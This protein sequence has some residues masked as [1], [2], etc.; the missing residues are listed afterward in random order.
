MI[1]L[2]EYFANTG[3]G[4]YVLAQ[5][6]A[7]STLTQ[8]QLLAQA[9]APAVDGTG[10]VVTQQGNRFDISGGSLSDDGANL[11]HSF[12]RLGLDSE[13][14]VNFISNPQINNILGRVTGGEPSLIN[15]LIQ[16]TGGNS[17]LFLMNPAGIIFGSNVQLNVPASFTATTATGIGLGGNN[18]F[19]AFGENNY[20]TLIG[21]PNIFVFDLSQPGS[22]INA[23]NLAV[24]PGQN[25]ILLGGSVGSTGQLTAPGGTSTVAAV[26]GENLVRISQPGHLLSLE[27]SPQ[28]DNN[29][30]L[31]PIVP[32]SLPS[33]L[34]GTAKDVETG[35]R[36][37]PD[38]T[39]Q[40]TGSD[41]RVENGDVVA[42][43]VTA[44]TATLSAANNLTLVESQ[45][46]TT[47]D[48]TLSAGSTVQIRDS[49]ANPFVAHAGG[50]LYVRGDRG[51]DILALNHPETPFISGGNLTLVSDGNI[52]GD[53]HFASR[54]GFSILNLSAG[55]GNFVSLYDPIIRANG[56]VVFGNY[57]GV[58]LKVE[59]TGSIQGGNITITGPDLSGSIPSFDP[60]FATLTNTNQNGALI[61]RA[62]RDL[63]TPINFPGNAGNTTFQSP[64]TPLLIPSGSIQVGNINTSSL[65][66]GIN[67]GSVILQAT[68]NITTGG[69]NTRWGRDGLAGRG[70]AGNITL[71]SREGAID[72]SN[73]VTS[74]T[75]NNGNGGDISF[76]AQNNI[77]TGTVEASVSQG[78]FQGNLVNGN[79]G[80]ISLSSRAGAI[81]TRNLEAITGNGNGG[82]IT[83][84]AKNDIIIDSVLANQWD[85]VTAKSG[86]IVLTSTEGSITLRGLSRTQDNDFGSAGKITL[87]ANNGS[88][89][90]NR[91]E[92]YSVSGNGAAI[93]INAG[94]DITIDS[95]DTSTDGSGVAG[96]ISLTSKAGA[97]NIKS[98]LSADSADSNG[99]SINL[100]ASGDITTAH[101]NSSGKRNAGNISLTSSGGGIN[102]SAGILNAAGG[103]NGG[104]ITL[105]APKNIATG[106]ITTFL[107]GFSGNSG[108]I[109]ITSSN[110]NIDTSK[111]ALIT[112][113]ALG[114]GGNITLNAADSITAA[115]INAFSFSS[116]GGKIDLTANH[117]ITTSGNIETN[118]N[119]IIFKAPVTLSENISVTSQGTGNIIF[120]NTVNGTQNLILN[121][122]TGIVQF[123]NAVGGSTPLN[124]LLVQGDISTTNPAGVDITTVNNI[125]TGN[126]TS[127]GGITL[128]SNSRN[129]TT[130][131]LDSSSTDN[132]GNVTLNARENVT[133]SQIN[134]QSLG[135]GRGGN[136]DITANRFFR[137]T[138]A[139]PD[140]NG[141]NASISTAGRVD[142]G[143]IIMRHGGGGITPFIAGNAGTNGTQGAITRGNR[144]PA[145]TISPTQTYYPTHK[146]DSDQIQIISVPRV[147]PIPPD[148]NP[149]PNPQL[150]SNSSPDPPQALALLVGD[151]LGADTQINQDPESGDYSFAWRI[152]DGRIL[153][154][155]APAVGLQI[156]QTDDIISSIDKLFE[157]QYEDYYR[158]NITDEVVTVQSLRQTLKTIKSHTG[159]SAVVIYARSFL[160]KLELVLVTPEENSIIK[161]VPEANAA[162]LK[163]QIEGFRNAVNKP[164][165]TFDY[166][167]S[168]KQLYQWLI[169]P[170]ESHLKELNI[171]TLIF[172]MD[173]GMRQIPMAAL[174][175][176]KGKQFLVEKY[177]LGSIPSVSLTNTRYKAWKD[178]DVLAMGASQ[179]KDQ[180]PLYWVPI[181]LDTITPKLL[182]G[183]SFLNEQFT[184]NN[185]KSYSLR[186]DFNIIHLAT[187]A[188]FQ[189][190]HVSNSY[191]QLSDKKLQLDEL[192][193]LGWNKL[194]QVELL[195]LS[196]CRTALGDRDAELGF[197]GLAIYAGVKS[198]L[199]SQ[200]Y[201]DDGGT[202]ALMSGFYYHLS[203]SGVIKAEALQQ[204]QIAM[205]RKKVRLVQG[206]LIGLEGLSSPPKLEGLGNKD[207]TH[208]YYWAGFTLVGSP[209]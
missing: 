14:I 30:N 125:I 95:L 136:V 87:N 197:A 8:Q 114:T 131:I 72:T 209:W 23:G 148:P 177:S 98:D 186:K 166:R 69:I 120:N 93:E 180:K 52:S 190:R 154:L 203:Q 6:P 183:K 145:Q 130:G 43:N 80:N 146:Q 168:S 123:N 110:A 89:T 155:N 39:V 73:G 164:L 92:A 76:V 27:I 9:I 3:F 150:N 162:N 147:P 206:Q 173:A 161:D 90:T 192:R 139:S 169:A 159:K 28:R 94:G 191:I 207:F 108:N 205:L 179:F 75:S 102:T 100:T 42:K 36:V 24:Q 111:G 149:L 104:N 22:I 134:A 174:Y 106:E 16:V 112:A 47:G 142:G 133:V 4:S 152:P 83:I 204:A 97:I 57:T 122:G 53:A 99:T 32:Q 182:R 84:E 151:I 172:C 128:T 109:S 202:Q 50:I 63:V 160:E 2:T 65:A 15:G 96:S 158:E 48:L 196:A 124:N 189:G 11:F 201:V 135:I 74:A 44:Q 13:Q 26:T 141:I 79:S 10:T 61:L 46:R 59:A 40:L 17:N 176:E 200:W 121:P 116:T 144:A 187:H 171:D 21:S 198:A 18:W 12:Q 113:S 188:D 31:L 81:T 156:N 5:L 25:L 105:F 37:N 29:G 54:G 34:T 127:S 107:S 167:K 85:R 194:P 119:D 208:P 45:L 185:L 41:F 140:Q 138:V 20:Q 77:V 62:G 157:Q 64:G 68:G 51:I 181:E 170:F 129:I 35:L 49:V 71:W 126:I 82:S 137:A 60:D 66:D 56:D 165:V 19:N 7:N 175:D 195:V 55:A 88:I 199:G 193:K 33:L 115:Q 117:N 1:V 153:S 118:N 132:G 91:L 143:S 184:L 103:V 70:N 58:A 86:D 78:D 178:S 67:G 163:Q 38:G 101:I